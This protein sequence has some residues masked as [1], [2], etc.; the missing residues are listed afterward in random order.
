MKKSFAHK[1]SPISLPPQ[2]FLLV[3]NV[4]ESSRQSFE[5]DRGIYFDE[6]LEVCKKSS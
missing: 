3:L 6:L 4:D 2:N 5:R 1:I